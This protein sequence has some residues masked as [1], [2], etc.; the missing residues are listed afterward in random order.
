MCRHIITISI[1]LAVEFKTKWRKNKYHS[2]SRIWKKNEVKGK[3]TPQCYWIL[4]HWTFLFL[5]I[6]R[7]PSCFQI[8]QEK[9][10]CLILL[11]FVHILRL[12]LSLVWLDLVFVLLLNVSL[13]FSLFNSWIWGFSW[14]YFI[15][16]SCLFRLLFLC[17]FPHEIELCTNCF[18][19]ALRLILIGGFYPAELFV[20]CTRLW[21]II[22]WVC[23]NVH[24]WKMLYPEILN[25]YFT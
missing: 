20:H 15:H 3:I 22:L 6:L 1:I 9:K 13:I 7:D 16:Q 5:E 11:C 23:F 18:T 8:V 2:S 25:L 4:T 24:I 14:P 21:W 12:I 10:V 19:L 17:L